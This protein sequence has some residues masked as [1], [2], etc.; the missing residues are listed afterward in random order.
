MPVSMSPIIIAAYSLSR[1]RSS[2]GRRA[3]QGV[4]KRGFG[5]RQV[6]VAAGEDVPLVRHQGHR[7][8]TSEPSPS[9]HCVNERALQ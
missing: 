5:E 1:R 3:A 9:F 2:G 4:P 7:D 6:G 8:R